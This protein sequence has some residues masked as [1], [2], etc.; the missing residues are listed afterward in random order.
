MKR[1]FFALL[2]SLA[3]TPL[4]AQNYT[5]TS[6]RDQQAAFKEY[7]TYAWA[8]QA[9][10]D[11]VLDYSGKDAKLKKHLKA[12]IKH[13]MTALGYQESSANPDILINYRVFEEPIEVEGHENYFRDANYW[14]DGEIK[15]GTVGVLPLNEMATGST[16]GTTGANE[17]QKYTF[18]DGTLLIQMVDAKRGEVVWQGYAS[19]ITKDGHFDKTE[20]NVVKAV[21]MIYGDYGSMISGL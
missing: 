12:A 2:L 14:G 6:N 13:E 4:V 1:N 18:E 8:K 15:A 21:S 3:V 20:K 9:N 10:S 5:V 7:K 16:T 11:K 17:T 19:G